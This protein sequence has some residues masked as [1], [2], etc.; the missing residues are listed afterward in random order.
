MP[1]CVIYAWLCGMPLD[2]NLHTFETSVLIITV[3]T[4]IFCVQASERERERYD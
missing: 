2:M 4:V 3:I 1:F